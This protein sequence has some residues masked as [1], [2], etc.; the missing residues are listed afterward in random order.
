MTGENSRKGWINVTQSFKHS[1]QPPSLPVV[2]PKRRVIAKADS[3]ATSHY[4]KPEDAHIL[5]HIQD[6][7]GPLVA[8]PDMSTLQSTQQGTI[9]LSLALTKT[10]TT[11]NILPGLKSS[12][13]LSLGN[14]C[15]DG[16][17]VILRKNDC[18]VIKDNEVVLSGIRNKHDGLWDIPFPQLSS[19]SNHIHQHQKLPS[20]SS[21]Y[22][23]S[24]NIIIRKNETKYNLARFLHASLVSPTNSTLL[25]KELPF[26]FSG[27]NYEAHHSQST[28]AKIYHSCSY[29]TGISKSKIYQSGTSNTR[30]CSCRCIPNT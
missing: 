7:N 21:P 24:L 3:G 16:C 6:H 2:S 19:L 9:P 18:H 12:S 4:W 14:F 10:S 1:F 29:Q 30:R 13:L 11:A 28:T 8:L 23:H 17:K 25:Q 27:F 26:H 22:H 20:L 5:D 15:N